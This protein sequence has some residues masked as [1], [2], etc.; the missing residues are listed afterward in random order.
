MLIGFLKP[1]ILLPGYDFSM[2]ELSYI[3]KHELIH[4]RRKDLWYKRLVFI[5]TAIHWFNPVVYAMAKAI[6]SQCEI[7]CDAE[8]VKKADIGTRQRY[9]EI[10]IGIIKNQSR[11]QTAF[12]TNFY[13]GEKGMK[14]R[15][16]SIMDT[17]QKKAAIVVL[18]LVLAATLG[19]GVV[20][21]ATSLPPVHESYATYVLSSGE[22]P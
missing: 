22:D 6:A 4:L 18:C 2:D 3:L 9:S 5:A 15:I 7:S 10:I 17:S 16:F 14:K 8:V 20:A 21:S 13:G 19:T 11:T 1:V 12:S